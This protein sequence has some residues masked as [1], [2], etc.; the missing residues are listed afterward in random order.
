M[1]APQQLFTCP[2][3]EGSGIEVYGITVYE[4]GCSF[5]HDSSDERECK[6]CGGTG[7]FVDDVDPDDDFAGAP[8]SEH[9]QFGVGA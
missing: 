9:S 2:C 7:W 4:P 3:C 6:E 1:G 8:W 5:S